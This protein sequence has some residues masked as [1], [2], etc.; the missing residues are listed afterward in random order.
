MSENRFKPAWIDQEPPARS[1][2][3]LFKWGDAKTFKHPN[4]RLYAYLKETFDLEDK[5]FYEPK[6]IGLEE[7]K[8][9]KKSNLTSAQIK[10]LE[11]IVGG[12]NLNLDEFNRLK[13]SYGKTMHDIL[14]LRKKKVENIPDAVV[15]PRSTE[16]VEKIVVFCNQQRI[17]IYTL[18]GQSSVTRATEAVQGG[19]ALNMTTHMYRI[20]SFNEI[21]HTVTVQPGIFGPDLESQLNAAVE[22]F[23][24]KHN[25]TCG[26]FPQSFEYSTVGG[27]IAT[28]SSGQQ[29]TYYGDIKDLVVSQKY[30]SPAGIL[31][32]KDFPASATGPD[33]NQIFMGSEGSFGILVEA[34]LKIFR[35]I[36][37]GRRYFSF[38][39]PD[40][41][42]ATAASR[43]ISQS[44][45]GLPSVLRIS[46]AEETDIALK[47]YGVE[48]SILDKFIRMRGFRPMERCLLLGQV[49]G[50]PR[51]T[52]K[53]KANLKAIARKNRGMYS[54][55]WVTKKWSVGRFKDPYLRDDLQDYGI[56]IDTLE[57]SV[58]WDNLDK[59]YK[60]VRNQVKKRDKTILMS[61]ASHFY[62]QGTNLYFIFI[63]KMKN[64]A[65]FY[66]LQKTIV[67]AMLKSG[68]SLSHHHGVGKLFALWFENYLGK[69]E[70][71]LLRAI[72]KFLDPKNI[73]NPGGTL[74]LDK[75][76]DDQ[77]V[78][79]EKR[80]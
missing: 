53:I 21:N 46:D 3:S 23:Q 9:K 70:L 31:E 66:K 68:A 76:F 29:S 63:A 4:D 44:Q 11:E 61:H 34:T 16:E 40:W 43:E 65:E 72:K 39:F 78:K 62:A 26:H 75:N 20:L 10:G 12:E 32:S 67:N 60:N 22:L 30:V 14:R 5:D 2:R 13:S 42:S 59:V 1:Y 37:E 35:N 41:Q 27:W 6:N 64:D 77:I 38:I 18:G 48:G 49:D 15:H 73:L 25:Y 56:Y 71:N 52:T 79:K 28:F 19:I 54:T 47:L 17:P 24:T 55:G 33:I 58:K 69:N 45:Q 7:V 51:I 74:A 50:H 80:N 8:F 57:C 36:P